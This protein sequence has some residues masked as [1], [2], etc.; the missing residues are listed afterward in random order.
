MV[1][2]GSGD[3]FEVA[4]LVLQFDKYQAYSVTKQAKDIAQEFENSSAG[5]VRFEGKDRCVTADDGV[6]FL[7][8]LLEAALWQLGSTLQLAFLFPSLDR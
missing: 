3:F 6:A 1:I 5:K 2:G 7:R 4:D 8:H